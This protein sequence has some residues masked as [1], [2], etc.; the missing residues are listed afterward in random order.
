[1]LGDA[2]A[3]LAVF[4]GERPT[5]DTAVACVSRERSGA[6]RVK[7]DSTAPVWVQLGT[8][9]AAA[10]AT[11]TLVA[12][13][14]GRRLELPPGTRDGAPSQTAA[15]RAAA[16]RCVTRVQGRSRRSRTRVAFALAGRRQSARQRNRF[17]T[18]PLTLQVFRGPVCAARIDLIGPRGRVYAR[19]TAS[20]LA[21][22]RAVRLRR[23]RR[24]VAGRYRLRVTVRSRTGRRIA[25]LTSS[26]APLRISQP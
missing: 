24:V 15:A 18:L 19:G 11:A 22:R 5:G 12:A 23:V 3:T 2:V 9:R 4:A 10:T 17:R 1:V 8:D 25:V 21:G 6:L 7:A 26:T 14:P 20:R 13:A 16:A